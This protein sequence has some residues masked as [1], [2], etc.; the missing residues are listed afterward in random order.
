MK[1]LNEI[2]VKY[3]E[4]Y[5]KLLESYRAAVKQA[6]DLKPELQR[7]AYKKAREEGLALARQ[8]KS[9]FIAEAKAALS[10]EEKE[11]SIQ[12]I[13]PK[14]TTEEKIL[15]RLDLLLTHQTLQTGDKLLINNLLEENKDN[16][17]VL[18]TMKSYLQYKEGFGEILEKINEATWTERDQLEQSKETVRQ[19]EAFS[20][21][22]QTTTV[23][24]H[25]FKKDFGFIEAGQAAWFGNDEKGLFSKDE[26]YFS[27]DTFA[28]DFSKLT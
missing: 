11:L 21:E 2:K 15:D 27:K 16:R 1:L 19:W 4:K 5:Q 26:N 20:D 6:G 8:I 17:Q 3:E 18:L 13:P 22:L 12:R 7:E 23:F 14:K 25:N 24:P 9:E 28:A 10:K